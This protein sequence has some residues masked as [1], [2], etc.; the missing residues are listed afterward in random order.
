MG[1]SVA[2]MVTKFPVKTLPIITGEPDYATIR[3]IIQTLYGNAASLPTTI[4]GRA[5]GH[6]GLIMTAVLYA[7]LTPMAYTVPD[8]PGLVVIHAANAPQAIRERNSITYK[9]ARR[10]YDNNANMDSAL[11]TQIIDAIEDTYL[12]ELRNKYTGYRFFQ[13]WPGLT[14]AAVNKYF[15]TSIDMHKGH[16]DQTRKN[17]RSTKNEHEDSESTSE[18]P[19]LQLVP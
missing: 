8:D 13:S 6:I 4:G 14:Q 7:T 1:L 17:V 19:I 5:H 12:C 15:P 16:M 3:Q 18:E 10:I 2:D 9:E 11:K